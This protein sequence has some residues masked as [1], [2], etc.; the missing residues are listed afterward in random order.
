M[1]LGRTDAT[2]A[3]FAFLGYVYGN[4]NNEI[5]SAAVFCVLTKSFDCVSHAVL[6][7]KLEHYGF[8]GIAFG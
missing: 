5:A 8:R 2:D 6:L 4:I 7:Q 1:D 3:I